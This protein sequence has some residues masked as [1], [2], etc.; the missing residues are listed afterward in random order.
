MTP[1]SEGTG[2]WDLLARLPGAA[3]PTLADAVAS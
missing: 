1:F 3:Y 2:A